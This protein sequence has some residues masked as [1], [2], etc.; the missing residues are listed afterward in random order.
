MDMGW[1]NFQGKNF[2]KVKWKMVI[3]MDPIEY[4]G[5]T[6]VFKNRT[7][8]QTYAFDFAFDKNEVTWVV[9]ADAQSALDLFSKWEWKI[10]ATIISDN[11]KEDRKVDISEFLVTKGETLLWKYGDVLKKII[12]LT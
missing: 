12:S 7:R 4:N 3:L 5:P 9:L 8:E 1:W 10:P 2:I 11:W 6:T